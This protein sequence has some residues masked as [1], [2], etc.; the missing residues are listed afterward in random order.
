MVAHA[1]VRVFD[2]NKD[3]I[4]VE[5]GRTKICTITIN[6][7]DEKKAFIEGHTKKNSNIDFIEIVPQDLSFNR[8]EWF[9]S[10]CETLSRKKIACDKIIVSSHFGPRFYGGSKKEL[11]L[12]FL[13]K[14]SCSSKCQNLFSK[15]QEAYLFTCNSL[16][17]TADDHRRSEAAS[18]LVRSEQGSTRQNY[19]ALQIAHDNSRSWAEE[20]AESRYGNY[21]E[22]GSF[23][24]RFMLVFGNLNQNHKI[25]G[26]SGVGS[27]GPTNAKAIRKSF[28]TGT[29]I[30]EILKSKNMTSRSGLLN[31]V[32]QMNRRYSCAMLTQ[33]PPS[34]AKGIIQSLK[35][36]NPNHRK[37]Y[38]RMIRFFMDYFS[39]HHAYRETE[40]EYT[41]LTQNSWSQDLKR[42]SDF[43]KFTLDALKS[44][45][46]PSSYR[47]RWGTF[48]Y[49]LGWISKSEYESQLSRGLYGLM[50]PP[51]NAETN[52]DV[53][54]FAKMFPDAVKLLGPVPVDLKNHPEARIKI[55]ELLRRLNR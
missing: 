26:F 20:A 14:M 31:S 52:D 11:D 47:L 50:R 37:A 22:G 1:K 55:N 49:E 54:Y 2:L 21:S 43:Q 41:Y 8:N 46:L 18:G 45:E 23:G 34:V 25:H 4:P 42:N 51:Y 40:D 6:S 10:A 32:E 9:A 44:K 13:E 19:V 53:L 39:P 36:P 7:P 24:D 35:K 3:K 33:Y 12:N 16:A 15:L 17:G 30:A 5:Q 27:T 28:A 48:S 29:P 38:G